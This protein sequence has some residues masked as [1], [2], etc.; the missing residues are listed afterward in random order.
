MA[1]LALLVLL[2]CLSQHC[3]DD[4]KLS[5]PNAAVLYL[6]TPLERDIRELKKSMTLLYENFNKRFQYPVYIFHEGDFSEELQRELVGVV[7]KMNV[8]IKFAPLGPP[9][10]LDLS[11]MTDNRWKNRP[12]PFGY[13]NMIRFW[14]K[15]LFEHP[16]VRALD[17]YMVR[18]VCSV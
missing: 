17:Y 7:P 1:W 11:K 14:V 16:D 18:G 9:E 3:A 4:T 8:Q 6:S 15:G 13:N 5:K 10:S 12:R 2:S